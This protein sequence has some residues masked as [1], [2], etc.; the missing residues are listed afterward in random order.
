MG[1]KNQTWMRRG[2]D[3]VG[4]AVSRDVFTISTCIK[5]W[6]VSEWGNRLLKVADMSHW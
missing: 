1:G 3:M 2:T 6:M 4:T 5:G